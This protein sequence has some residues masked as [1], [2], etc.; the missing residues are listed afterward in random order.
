VQQSAEGVDTSL[1]RLNQVG[2]AIGSEGELTFD[3][4][5]FDEAYAADPEAVENLFAAFEA[6]TAASEEIAPGV[7]VVATGQTALSRG[8][9]EI[10]GDLA[11]RL[12]NS[13]DGTITLA[14]R[15]YD[16][17]IEVLNDRIEEFDIRLANK[18]ERL[19]NQFTALELALARLQ[20]QSGALQLLAGSAALSQSAFGL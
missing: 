8:F 17:R 2:I 16:D 15:G 5:R 4:E 6:E 13:I 10:F 19:Q 7:T 3:R 11:E 1:Q 18:R 9:G 14:S 12:T 20:E